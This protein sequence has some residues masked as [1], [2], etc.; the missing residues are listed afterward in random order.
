MALIRGFIAVL[1]GYVITAAVAMGIV[2]SLF[3][4]GVESSPK[5]VIFA[6]LGLAAGAAIGGAL[7]TLIVGNANSPAIYITIGL[8]IAVAVRA[9]FLGLGVE[10]D[11][12]RLLST[13]AQGIGF[14]V[15]ASGAAYKVGER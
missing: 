5:S 2:R 12:Y 4:S 14:L 15:G 3:D 10:P 13:I 1:V 8:V 9:N 7:C 11:W 6:L